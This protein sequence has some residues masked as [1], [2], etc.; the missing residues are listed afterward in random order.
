MALAQGETVV[1][2]CKQIGV[3][4]QTYCRWRKEFGGVRLE[5]PILTVRRFITEHPRLLFEGA[6]AWNRF[7][8]TNDDAD[9]EGRFLTI[10]EEEQPADQIHVVLNWFEELKR[11][12][13]TD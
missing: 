11:L 2:V 1:Q 12:V 9:S 10:K 5:R 8:V 3:I 6:Y 4:E 7:I 13:P